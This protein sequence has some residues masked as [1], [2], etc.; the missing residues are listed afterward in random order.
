[1][2]KHRKPERFQIVATRK[3]GDE[4]FAGCADI[5]IH[6]SGKFLYA[7]TE[8]TSMKLFFLKLTRIPESS[9]GGKVI[10]QE[11]KLPGISL[12]LPMAGFYCALTENQQHRDIP[13]RR[14]NRETHPD[15]K[16]ARCAGTGLPSIYTL[17]NYFISRILSSTPSTPFI[18]FFRS[19]T[20]V[21]P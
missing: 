17:K 2:K 6:P 5:H 21:S 8:G 15:R 9:P 11:E 18:R 12:F 14:R 20:S 16:H 19:E 13:H 7:T 3:E 1:M 4:R 10:L